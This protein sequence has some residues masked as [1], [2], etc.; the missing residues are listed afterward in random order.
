[1]AT[2]QAKYVPHITYDTYF[3]KGTPPPGAGAPT[4]PVDTGITVGVLPWS[5]LQA[6]VGYDVLLPS[7]DPVFAFLNGKICTPE[8]SLFT[9]S[10][11]IGGGIYNVGFRKNVTNYNML[12][13]MAQKSLPI[14]GYV[15]GGVYH[16][17]TDALFTNSDGDIVKTG[18]MFAWSSPDINV[19]VRG[20]KKLTV[21]ADVQTGKNAFG[22]G[23]VGA[24]LYFNDYVALIVGPVFFVDS[25][26]Q[27][28]GAKRMWTMQ[29]D[30]D[31]PFGR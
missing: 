22:G 21:I 2:C 18:A 23:G 20:L 6:E 27:P 30:I 14:G 26:V 4:Y 12:H 31:V 24:N 19:N 17:L 15:A 10:P 16:G 28:G 8:G 7:S 11:A 3:G 9:G 1:V 13:L 29:L 25:G 5:K